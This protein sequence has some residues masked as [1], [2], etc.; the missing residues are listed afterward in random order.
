[1][2]DLAPLETLYDGKQGDEIPLPPELAALYGPLSITRHRDRPHVMANFVSTMDGVVSLGVPGH[3]GGAEISGANREDRMVM[4]LLRAISDV[5][6]VGAS[7][8]R[9]VPRHIWTA[10]HIFKPLAEAYQQL[11]A[12]MGKAEPP[13]NVFVSASGDLDL[14]APVFTKGEV[15]VLVVT[16]P[17]GALRLSG[18]RI[19]SSA[20]IVVPPGVPEDA[21]S[22]TAGSIMQVLT[23]Q[24]GYP[25]P[26]RALILVEGGPRLVSTFWSEG[27]LDELFLT[28]SPQV[29]GRDDVVR[30]LS[31]AEGHLF[32]PDDPIWGA[33][34][35]VKRRGNHL[36]LRYAFERDRASP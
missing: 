21:R 35:G 29:A 17:R 31:L 26:S 14:E 19:P 11:R 7:T 30:R 5:V 24:Q 16:T 9:V 4:G 6:M 34:V 25:L 23:A 28:L 15:P 18:Q 10:E 32:A 3:T 12:D 13:L 1:M 20:N 8:F 22:V 33:L 27:L 36:F 2:G